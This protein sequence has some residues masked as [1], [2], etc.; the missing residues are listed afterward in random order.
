MMHM[1]MMNMNCGSLMM[2]AMGLGWL[3]SLGLVGSLIVLIWVVIRRVRR[4]P[5]SGESWRARMTQ[6]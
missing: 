2:V 5:T 4:T 1:D 6:P 3:F